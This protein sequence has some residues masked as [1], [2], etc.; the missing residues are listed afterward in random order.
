MQTV[1]D[2]DQ[3]YEPPMVAGTGPK[4]DVDHARIVQEPVAEAAVLSSTKDV[5]S[6]VEMR[7]CERGHFVRYHAPVSPFSAIDAPP[8]LCCES[9]RSE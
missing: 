8:H 7:A 5:M 4:N 6:I 3:A 9:E 2:G 1:V